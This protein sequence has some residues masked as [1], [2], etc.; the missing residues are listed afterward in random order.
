MAEKVEIILEADDQA[1]GQIQNVDGALKDLS[2]TATVDVS[3]AM[4]DLRAA[5][6]D[7]F[8]DVTAVVKEFV[9]A[10]SEAETVQVRMEAQ[11][12]AIGKTAPVTAEKI[13]ELADEIAKLS[14]FD[15]EALVEG[16]ATLLRF[17]NLSEE[18]FEKATRG[19]ADLAAMT[20]MDLVSAFRQVGIALDNP[21]QGFGRLKRQIGDLTDAEKE[22]I[23]ALMEAG[24]VA[25]A[26]AIILDALARKTDG[27]A[28]AIG[29]TFAGKVAIANTNVGNFMEDTGKKLTDMLKG[30]PQWA[31]DA[32]VGIQTLGG[33][34]GPVLGDLSDIAIIAQ[35]LKGMGG[36]SG[37]LG[38]ANLATLGI[39][40]GAIALAVGA[41]VAVWYQWNQQIVKT[42][43]EGQKNVQ[44]TWTKFFS[45]LEAQGKSATE[46]VDEY[47][48]AQ[49]R[50]N[51]QL[52]NANPIV[53]AFIQDKEQ[54]ANADAQL[55]ETIKRVSGTQEEY[56][57]AMAR[58]HETSVGVQQ[59][60]QTISQSSQQTANIVGDS[61]KKMNEAWR[62]SGVVM[63]QEAQK[64]NTVGQ[65]AANGIWKGFSEWWKTV[66]A[67]IV[68]AILDLIASIQSALGA[69]S[70]SQVMADLVG[71]SM[72]QG[73]QMGFAKQLGGGMSLAPV[74]LG[75]GGGRS[76]GPMTVVVN[77]SPGVSIADRADVSGKLV[78]YI[79]EA[80]R[81]M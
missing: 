61:Q 35:S 18:Q 12:K 11:L 8:S 70:P 73:I 58:F 2:V 49:Q 5:T 57:A 9:A 14:G 32:G 60:N 56:N 34:L 24:D 71:K 22:Q 48:A 6:M 41:L 43:E 63:N 66:K 77:Y 3:Q 36:L 16:Q 64:F 27:A 76:G 13:N 44:N 21:E 46:I 15:D 33:Y 54:L 4:Q 81:K 23:K 40:I 28:E 78:P 65:T 25:G 69:H 51:E 47:R 45:D 55:E 26:Q 68:Q 79:R 7:L 59:D 53:R 20:G 1:T 52:A 30:L 50:V 19:A 80:M 38:V 74:G 37:V 17:G 31:F 39:T 72:A 75:I 62:Q 10:A 29:D 42:N 67:N